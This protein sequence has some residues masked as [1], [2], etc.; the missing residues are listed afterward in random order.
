MKNYCQIRT[1]KPKQLE[2][3]RKKMNKEIFQMSFKQTA[4]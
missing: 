1:E 2:Q 3:Q 4:S